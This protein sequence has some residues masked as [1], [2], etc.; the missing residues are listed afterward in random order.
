MGLG[1]TVDGIKIKAR[2]PDQ[3][4]SNLMLINCQGGGL[5]KVPARQ[6]QLR[7]RLCN[8]TGPAHC[9]AG[10][11]PLSRCRLLNTDPWAGL[12]RATKMTEK[13]PPRAEIW[14]PLRRLRLE[15]DASGT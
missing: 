3:S 5:P 11:K 14:E 10:I 2:N 4:K 13:Q 7:G 8:K 6:G 1:Q 15:S 9:V 12:I